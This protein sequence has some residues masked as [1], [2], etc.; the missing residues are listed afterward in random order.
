MNCIILNS[1]VCGLLIVKTCTVIIISNSISRFFFLLPV[2]YNLFLNMRN[3]AFGV[4]TLS[5]C[6]CVFLFMYVCVC[7][8][9]CLCVCLCLYAC[10]FV[11][12]IPK[13]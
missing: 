8:C 13:F 9:V 5:V 1:F 3:L 12:V 7:V 10:V 6:L 11:C 2:S 4:T